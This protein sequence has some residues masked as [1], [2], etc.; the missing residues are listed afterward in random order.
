MLN[1][2]QNSNESSKNLQKLR[3]DFYES[4]IGETI[5]ITFPSGGLGIVDAHPSKYNHRPAILDLVRGKKIHF[6]CLTHP[7]EDHA[8]D[9]VKVLETHPA[10]ESFWSTLHDIPAFVFWA[11][12]TVSFPSE[13]RDRIAGL[14]QGYANCFLDL[15][16]AVGSKDIP[17]HDLRS[18]LEARI[19]DGVEIHCL[20][21]DEGSKNS[22]FKTFKTRLEKPEAKF[23]NF[24]LLSAVFALKYGES[25]VVLGADALK[26]NWEHALKIFHKRQLP[27]AR[28]LKVPHH[29]ARNAIDLGRNAKTYL[30]VCSQNPKAKAVIFAGDKKHPDDGVFEKIKSRTE[31]I[32]LSN[33]RKTIS[34]VNPL[35]IQLPG[36]TFIDPSPVCNPVVSFELDSNGNLTVLAGND[37]LACCI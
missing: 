2:K 25:V 23:P 11:T 17:R 19:L 1:E 29:G 14:N 15:L 32:C 24:N 34:Q 31:A 3:L 16:D 36:A 6:V 21:P 37:C 20:S 33:G 27:K 4:G 26:E 22:F 30:D 13:L 18:D 5:I 28:V 10:V 9:L 12:Q 8:L 35:R 7:H